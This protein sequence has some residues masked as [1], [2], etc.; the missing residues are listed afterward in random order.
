MT[1]FLSNLSI[2]GKITALLVMPVLAL[3][4]FSAANIVL[5]IKTLERSSAMKELAQLVI[6]AGA[7]IH[8]LQLE[9]T[10]STPHQAPSATTRADLSA[11]RRQSDARIETFYR[12]NQT[13]SEVSRRPS[14]R[15]SL[16]P[17]HYQLALISTAREQVDSGNTAEASPAM[18]FKNINTTLLEFVAFLAHDTGNAHMALGISSLAHLLHSKER[19][20]IENNLVS[21]VLTTNHRSSSVATQVIALKAQQEAYNQ[22]FFATASNEQQ[23]K[24]IEIL[25]NT[26]DIARLRAKLIHNPSAL[27]PS[28]D[29][30]LWKTSNSELIE[31][32]RALEVSMGTELLQLSQNQYEAAQ[33]AALLETTAAFLALFIC[34]FMGRTLAAE[35]QKSLLDIRTALHSLLAGDFSNPLRSV[36]TDEIAEIA[37]STEKTRVQ[38]GS[39]IEQLKQSAGDLSVSC[40]EM[41]KQTAEISQSNRHQ[42][43]E[44]HQ[45]VTCL[46]QVSTTGSSSAEYASDA[47]S[48]ATQAQSASKRGNGIAQELVASMEE[49]GQASSQIA[50]I[51]NTIDEIAFQTNLLALNAAVEAARAGESGRGFAVVA[52]EVRSLAGRASAAAKSITN[53]IDNA[54][55]R[56]DEGTAGVDKSEKNLREI[57]DSIEHVA[58]MMEEITQT[59]KQQNQDI[60]SVESGLV[61][62]TS[63][64]Q[65][66]TEAMVTAQQCSQDAHAETQRLNHLLARFTLPR[67]A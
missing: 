24:F 66:Q 1:P 3:L 13:L 19:A 54:A 25:N 47:A 5:N 27:K 46:Q 51:N 14:F 61:N 62:M 9:R 55:S 50:D 21:P 2:R 58:S 16:E 26:D 41:D 52:N 8:A 30:T 36:G 67:A 45:A 44:L 17:V 18:L 59:S 31:Q 64:N 37:S 60:D 22:A 32:L 28:L 35:Q 20:N 65:Q 57:S 63:H 56:V 53:L 7:V 15:A 38:L 6:D 43:A 10:L 49:I 40:A 34:F 4:Y 33:S 48:A 42:T 29:T 39:W 12:Y 23:N 11:Q